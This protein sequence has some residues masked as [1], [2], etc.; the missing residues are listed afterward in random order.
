M[1]L[2]MKQYHSSGIHFMF[3]YKPAQTFYT[4]VSTVGFAA[5]LQRLYCGGGGGGIG[6]GG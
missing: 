6:V 5:G 3:V 4:A 1:E 2:R